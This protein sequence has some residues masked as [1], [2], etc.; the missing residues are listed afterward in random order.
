MY[1][2]DMIILNKNKLRFGIKDIFIKKYC[3]W[4]ILINVRCTINILNLFFLNLIFLKLLKLF[5]LK[6]HVN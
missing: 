1:T 6:M 3:F 2:R 4:N 5:N